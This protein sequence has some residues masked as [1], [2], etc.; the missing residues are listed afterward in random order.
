MM[1]RWL[2]AQAQ[3]VLEGA[4]D[5]MLG[6]VLKAMHVP[7]LRSAIEQHL[8]HL[9]TTFSYE[10]AIPNLQVRQQKEMQDRA[11][12]LLQCMAAQWR[13]GLHILIVIQYACIRTIPCAAI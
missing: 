6:S 9:A 8:H 7:A 10:K 5:R 12:H 3:A 11:S 2:R 13:K 1:F 4:I